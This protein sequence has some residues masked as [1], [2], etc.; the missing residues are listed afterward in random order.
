[1]NCKT[2]RLEEDPF[3]KNVERFG[4]LYHKVFFLMR[5]LQT[6]LQVRNMKNNIYDSY[7]TVIKNRDDEEVVNNRYQ[8][9]ENDYIDFLDLSLL[10]STLEEKITMKY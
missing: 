2:F 8:D 5:F 10:I 6:K 9:N 7:Y 4:K 1:M 3:S